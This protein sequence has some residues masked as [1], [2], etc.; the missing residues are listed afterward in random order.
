MASLSSPVKRSDFSERVALALYI[1]S[2]R[3]EKQRKYSENEAAYS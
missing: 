3:P 1:E 2:R